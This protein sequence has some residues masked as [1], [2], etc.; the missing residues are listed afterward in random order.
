MQR[1]HLVIEWK[2][3][4]LQLLASGAMLVPSE[5]MLV[6]ADLHLGKAAHFRKNG[7][8]LPKPVNQNN[9]WK[10]SQVIADLQPNS[11]LFLGDLFHSVLNAEWNEWIDFLDNYPNIQRLLVNGNHDIL[12]EKLYVESGFRIFE[13]FGIQNLRFSHDIIENEDENTLLICGHVHPAVRLTSKWHKGMRLPC[14]YLHEGILLL[15]A[16]GEFTGVKSI[17]PS[18]KSKVFAISGDEIIDLSS[19]A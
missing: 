17:N 19:K 3:T 18:R 5:Q 9:L 14:F 7:I 4:A 11:I 8:P 13:S 6:V 16:F 2:G 12:D 10:L 15:P 1:H